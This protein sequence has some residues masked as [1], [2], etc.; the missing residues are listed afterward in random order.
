VRV[1]VCSIVCFFVSLFVSLVGWVFVGIW[2]FFFV[3]HLG[4]TS[5]VCFLQFGWAFSVCFAF[6]GPWGS[7]VAPW[8]SIVAPCAPFWDSW[9]TCC[10]FSTFFLALGL[11]FDTPGLHLGTLW[12]PF[13]C[14]FKTLGRDPGPFGDF[15][16]KVMKKVHKSGEKGSPNTC[17]FDEISGF[18]R[19]WKN[20]FRLRRRERIGVQAIN[21]LYFCLHFRSSF[22]ASFFRGFWLPLEAQ[23]GGV[24]DTGGTPLNEFN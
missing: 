2:F 24:G 10:R 9:A 21:F 17:L 13:W 16:G 23:K 12:R 20:E 14:L 22:L 8:G 4:V 7:N 15:F 18:P 19:K 11:N 6:V 5:G 1:C 3:W